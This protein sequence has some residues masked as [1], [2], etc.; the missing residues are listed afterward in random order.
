[1]CALL[2]QPAGALGLHAP[3]VLELLAT[4]SSSLCLPS[5]LAVTVTAA[6]HAADAAS[7][8]C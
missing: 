2:L 7:T 5:L 8:P 3:D 1:M 6:E 4:C